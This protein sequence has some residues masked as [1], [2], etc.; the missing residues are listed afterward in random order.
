MAVINDNNAGN[1]L[2]GTNGADS[3]APA[4]QDFML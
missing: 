4:A 1:V 3:R 2:E